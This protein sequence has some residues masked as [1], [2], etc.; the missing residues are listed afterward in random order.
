M[1]DRTMGLG[2]DPAL[3]RDE[4][5]AIV[6]S[7][8][9]AIVS[10]DL[11]G[12][13]RSWNNGAERLF[14]FTATEAIGKPITILIPDDRLIEEER[15]LAS[16]RSG[17]R[18][19][20]YETVRRRKDGTLLNISLAV[21]PVRDATGRVVGA[22]KIARDITEPK[23]AEVSL[24]KRMEEQAALHHLTDRLYRAQS[25]DD[26]T[27][28]SL[29][30]IHEALG[31]DR[32]SIL[33]F[34]VSGV[35][36]FVAWR[37]LSESYRNA[38]DGHSPW[39]ADAKDPRPI[40]VEDI[41]C[42]DEAEALK[43]IVKQEGIGS[44]AFI[45]L[46]VG[47]RLTGKFMTYYRT[48]HAFHPHEAELLLT[49]ARQLGF[50]L[51][52]LQ[53]EEARRQSEQAL[54]A[55]RELLQ[56]MFDRIPVMLTM[57]EPDTK[58]LRLNP[59]FES[60]VGWSTGEAQGVSLMERCY[61]DPNYRAEVGTFM[62][63]CRD[64]WMDIRMRT[65]E[66]RDIDTSWANI[67]LS[68]GT[69]IGIG[70]D[71]TQR[72]K[73]ERLQQLLLSEL[74]HRVKNTLATVQAI[75]NQTVRRAISPHEFASSFSGRLQAL[76]RTHSLLTETTW[77]GADLLA[78][79]R[80]QLLLGSGEDERISCCGP[81]VR[82]PPQTALHLALVLHE[83][84][85]NARKYGALSTSPGRLSVDWQLRGNEDQQ[86]LLRWR[87][88]NG[89]PVEE[90]NTR[91]F[92][93]TLIEQSLQGSGGGANI[94]YGSGGLT[95]EITLP[96]PEITVATMPELAPDRNG[97]NVANLPLEKKAGSTSNAR[98]LVVDDEPL[99]AMD[100]VTILDEVGCTVLGPVGTVGA[101][102]ALIDKHEFDFA[103]L[104]ANLGGHSAE[105]LARAIAAR[106]IPFAFITGYT[107]AALAA[108]FRSVPVVGKPFSRQQIK[109]LVRRLAPRAPHALS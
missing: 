38:V 25:L 55:E 71:I 106:R 5:S 66:G 94:I 50:G 60:T 13:I 35:M 78:L 8:E 77:Q 7:S 33:L 54:R 46:V 18:V 32:S 82:L 22:A 103:L 93:A 52:R 81:T 51:G 102:R 69:Q 107:R 57:Y 64:G 74:N 72:K 1:R 101:A 87:E 92:G 40:F 61:P 83:L 41:D 44:L 42:A 68:G 58:V 26:M 100:L 2:S 34:D 65:K 76:A 36:R 29:D 39:T 96:I 12:I 15:I 86:L 53:A 62:E 28:A 104:D 49:I 63:S 89:P 84:G 31:C 73:S 59:A 23:R 70:L 9:D 19:T 80:D 20:P 48:P 105:T 30:A 43:T 10:K 37:G 14:G 109:D 24:A 45:P 56:T 88:H 4:L 67:R 17:K 11:R 90:P 97:V 95:C 21:S 47:D 79:V 75:A 16:I 85:T 3:L 108:D 27:A 6:E 99:V 98:V 91:G